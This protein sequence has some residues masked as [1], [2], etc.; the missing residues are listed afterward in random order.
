MSNIT[1][2]FKAFTTPK[3]YKYRKLVEIDG[4][5]KITVVVNDFYNEKINKLF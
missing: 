3:R 2:I 4:W 5:H 1:L